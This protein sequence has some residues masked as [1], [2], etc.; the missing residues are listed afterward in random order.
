MSEFWTVI[1]CVSLVF[2]AVMLVVISYNIERIADVME[3]AK[4]VEEVGRN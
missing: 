3:C 1:G 2:I 4:A